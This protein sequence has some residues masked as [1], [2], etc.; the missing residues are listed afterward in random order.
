M[1]VP[2]LRSE[3]RSARQRSSSFFSADVFTAACV[4]R[5]RFLALSNSSSPAGVRL[6]QGVMYAQGFNRFNAEIK[7]VYPACIV[8]HDVIKLHP[9]K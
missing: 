2:W 5:D 9:I 6:Q 4:L 7:Q 1:N 3:V 8:R